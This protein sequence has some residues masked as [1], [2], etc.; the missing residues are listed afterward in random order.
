[1][2]VDLPSIGTKLQ[3]QP[4]VLAEYNVSV[5]SSFYDATNAP[6]VGV[7]SFMILGQISGFEN[8]HSSAQ[9]LLAS[10]NERANDIVVSGGFVNARALRTILTIQG[11][12]M[13]KEGGEL[14]IHS[15]R[16]L[17]KC[18]QWYY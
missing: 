14:I 3:D 5:P 11:E 9:E 1:M 18:C 16:S 15:T 2:Q 6:I 7:A 13:L 10:V 4:L 17:L 12:S 8:G